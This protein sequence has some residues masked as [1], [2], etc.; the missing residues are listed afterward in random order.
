MKIKK[1]KKKIKQNEKVKES[2]KLKRR[3][4]KFLAEMEDIM[5]ILYGDELPKKK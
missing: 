4:K 3:V 2:K 5:N 1:L